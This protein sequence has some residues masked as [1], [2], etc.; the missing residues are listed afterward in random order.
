MPERCLCQELELIIKQ[1]DIWAIGI[2]IFEMVNGRPPYAKARDKRWLGM[3]L[4]RNPPRLQPSEEVSKELCAFMEWILQVA[5][6]K[7]PKA[8]DILDHPYIK[9][10]EKSHPTSLLVDLVIEFNQWESEG[11]S[12]YSLF[13]PNDSE[14]NPEQVSASDEEV[15]TSWRFSM[16]SSGDLDLFDIAKANDDVDFEQAVT[17]PADLRRAPS[18]KVDG[19]HDFPSSYNRREFGSVCGQL[20]LICC[21]TDKNTQAMTSTVLLWLRS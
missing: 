18:I 21:V 15:D 16:V 12:R 8:T 19:Q 1:V 6:E 2:T 14:S 3:E 4:K 5:P 17:K 9:G 13:L 20:H 10:T 7:R 11:G